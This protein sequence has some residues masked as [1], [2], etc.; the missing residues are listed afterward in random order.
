[1][2]TN[3]LIYRATMGTIT[4]EELSK[5]ASSLQARK[6]DIYEHILVLGRACATQFREDVESFLT[7]EDDPMLARLALQVLCCYWDLA[8]EY[9]SEI[10]QFV[11]KI[12]WDEDEDVRVMAVSCSVSL[13]ASAQHND[14]LTEVY[15]IATDTRE[16]AVI[17]QAAYEALAISAGKNILELPTPVRFNID[18]DMDP[19]ILEDIK[20][21][22]SGK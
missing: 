9:A 6:G 22:I 17:R 11:S 19:K 18:V 21:R 16:D 12:D 10:K 13:L 15:R 5:V 20:R 7:C 14:L 4:A 8:Q 2:T 1:M 3:N